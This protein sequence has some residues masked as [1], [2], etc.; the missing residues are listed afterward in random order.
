MKLKIKSAQVKA[1]VTVNQQLLFLYR[2]I[3]KSILQ[4]QEEAG[5]GDGVLEQ[6]AKDLKMEFPG[7]K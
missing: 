4:R 7:M 2:E 3:G 1:M 5:W 6:T